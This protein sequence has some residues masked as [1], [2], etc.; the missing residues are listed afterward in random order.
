MPS[1]RRRF[2]AAALIS[3]AVAAGPVQAGAVAL[4]DLAIRSVAPGSRA[5]H[6][7]DA[8]RVRMTV[9]N[10]GAARARR[11][12][13]AIYLSK[14]GRKRRL[15]LRRTPGLDAGRRVRRTPRA[16]IPVQTPTGSY[17]LVACADARHSVRERRERNNCRRSRHRL[18]VLSS[19][20]GDRTLPK[21]SGLDAATTCI[22]GPI[23]SGVE[24]RYHL[25]W[26]P[27]TDDKTP[28]KEL[29]YDVFQAAAPRG[30]DF[31]KP[32]YTSDPG[33]TSFTTPPLTSDKSWYFVVR[34]RDRAGNRDRNRVERQ[35]E[36]LCL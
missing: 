26:R 2:V 22:P 32:S 30:E 6:P 31:R 35:G 8:L 24:S 9:S 17:R 11:S 36:N 15:R 3:A 4:P 16:R 34:A 13:T 23:G 25:S 21:F 33:A 28:Q 29:V 14:D 10:R 1:T 5:L 18:R 7:G 12:V 20:A 19:P 27:A